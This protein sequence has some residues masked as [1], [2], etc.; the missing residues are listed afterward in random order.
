MKLTY[1]LNL[2]LLVL[3]AL[4]SCEK[5]SVENCAVEGEQ[6]TFTFYK[7]LSQDSYS[8]ALEL[9]DMDSSELKLFERDYVN[10]GKLL[11][12]KYWKTDLV[13]KAENYCLCVTSYVYFSE[14]RYSRIEEVWLKRMENNEIKIGF[15]YSRY[16]MTENEFLRFDSLVNSGIDTSYFSKLGIYQ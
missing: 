3:I 2:A 4:C 7:N 11:K 16:A 14:C 12:Y 8:Q 6:I 9:T 5:K 1:R 15:I 10:C 13:G